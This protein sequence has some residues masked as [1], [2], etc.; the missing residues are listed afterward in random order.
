MS[1]YDPLRDYLSNYKGNKVAQT[2]RQI[3]DILRDKLPSSA[4][5]YRP[6]WGND[7]THIQAIAWLK[8]GWKVDAVNL[9]RQKVIFKKQP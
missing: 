4:Y 3:E 2:F 9:T 6:W 5:T 7:K 1:K 8:A